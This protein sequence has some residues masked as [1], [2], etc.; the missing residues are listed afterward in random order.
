V[1][2]AKTSIVRAI[3]YKSGFRPA[4]LLTQSYLF[5]DDII[6]Q[7]SSG[8]RPATGWPTGT[9][10]DQV[11]DYG[12]DAFV[13][14]SRNPQIG[15][16]DKVKSALRA[17][18]TIS[19]V[20]DLPNLFS[21]DS[22]IWGNPYNRGSAWERPAS[23]EMIGDTGPD[24]GF[25]INGGLRIR[26]G[27]SRSGGNPKHSLRLFFRGEYGAS[28]LQYPLFGDDGGSSF[29]KID[30]RTSQNYS[31]S[32]Q[33]DGNNTFIREETTRELQGAMGHLHTR[34]RYYH[35]YLN[36]QYWGLYATDERPE[37]AFAET[38]L[39]GNKEDYDTV[40][41]EQDQGYITGV[42]DGNLDA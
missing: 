23:I 30:L 5:L 10:N 6:R 27:F 31:W 3:A 24:G 12:M 39:G 17:I 37:A 8:K 26:G 1:N 35:L 42:T 7:S 41:G 9:V 11:A 32:F 36:G 4:P 33:G 22:G 15:G 25:E 29:D 40:K 34:S 28:K 38:Y 2:I 19:I 21:P 13:V 20:T 14:N 16:V 18:P